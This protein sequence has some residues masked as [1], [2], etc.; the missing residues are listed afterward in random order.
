MPPLDTQT[1]HA[2]AVST[3]NTQYCRIDL[4]ANPDP[5]LPYERL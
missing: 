2:G 1:L 4:L 3:L 5:G